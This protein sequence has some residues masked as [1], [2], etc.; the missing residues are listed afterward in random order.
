MPSSVSVR[1]SVRGCLVLRSTQSGYGRLFFFF[2]GKKK[3]LL[4]V[5]E[6]DMKRYARAREFEKAEEVSSPYVFTNTHTGCGTH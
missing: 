5:L 2:S 6:R 3:Q 4:A 1:G